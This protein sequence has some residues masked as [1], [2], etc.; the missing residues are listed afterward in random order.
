MTTERGL[1]A[2]TTY[3]GNVEHILQANVPL[4]NEEATD[5]Q[6]PEVGPGHP[7]IGSLFEMSEHTNGSLK[8]IGTY[9]SQD[10]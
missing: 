2:E 7:C 3:I 9:K 1:F 6:Y 4:M 8:C 10:S 5:G